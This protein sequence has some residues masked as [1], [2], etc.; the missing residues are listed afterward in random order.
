MAK[1]S[2]TDHKKLFLQAEKR[3]RQEDERLKQTEPREK[4]R[5]ERNQRSTF[6]KLLRFCHGLQ[7]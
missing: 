5:R 4:Q 2:L 6:A 7:P 1:S 3:Q